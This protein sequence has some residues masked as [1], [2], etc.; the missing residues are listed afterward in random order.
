MKRLLPLFLVAPL[1]SAELVDVTFEL[2]PASASVNTLDLGLAVSFFTSSAKSEASGTVS[3]RLEIDPTNGEISTFEFLE[4]DVSATDVNFQAGFG[5]LG[6]NLNA[7]GLGGT[8]DTPLPPS[9]VTGGQ[10]PA[11]DHELLINEGMLTGFALG[12]P[13]PAQNFAET[14]VAGAGT[15]ATFVTIAA[16]KNEAQSSE[17]LT[18]Y[19]LE[20]IFPVDIT[21]VI[22]VDGLSA[23]VTANGTVRA[24]GQTSFEEAPPNPYL[25]WAAANG[26]SEAL[27]TDNDFSFQLPNGLFWALG[28]RAGE[29][30]QN[31]A[32]TAQGVFQLTVP[33]RGTI[34]EV[35]VQLSSDLMDPENW[36]RIGT[37]PAGSTGVQGPFGTGGGTQFLRLSVA[38]P[39]DE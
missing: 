30:A 39:T 34:A 10:S 14:P 5:A 4:G 19:D 20:F 26:M 32:P 27:F 13:V 7:T 31:L 1:G 23:T 9:I 37:I 22:D 38:D 16:T 18:V 24:T 11:P 12:S 36:T 21:Q 35:E 25:A 8:L 2:T 17:T 33:D 15:A 6:Y 29:D 3:T 28:Y